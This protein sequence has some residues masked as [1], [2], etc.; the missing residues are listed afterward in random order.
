MKL[1]VLGFFQDIFNFLKA[2]SVLGID[3]GTTSI[4]VVEVSK[5]SGRFKLENYSILETRKY[6]EHPNQAIQTSSLKIDEEEVVELFRIILNELKP[7]SKTV[8]ASMPAFSSFIT[9]IDMPLLS[10]EETAK[11][12]AF[13]AKQYIP[14]PVNEVSIDWLKVEEFESSR[15]GRLQRILLIGVPNEIIK[16]YKNIFKA[17]DLRLITLEVEN[18]SLVRTLGSLDAVTMVVDIG[19]ESTNTII[20]EKGV[21]KHSSQT[22]Y[23]GIHLTQA[24]SK[25]LGI[26]TLRAE[27]LKR[28]RGLLGSGGESE[29]STLILPFLDVII[30][31]VKYARDS[32]ERRYSKKV[33][34]LILVGGGANLLGIEK[35]FGNQMDLVI[36]AP[37]TFANLEYNP[38]L[39]PAVKGLARQ[40]PVA[41]GLAKKYFT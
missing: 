17:A 37:P 28:R 12:V 22:D 26:S 35:Y 21:L 31:E 27:E 20:T 14:L 2:G 23:G 5:K 38:E 15:G 34:K 6:L 33:E 29:L 41:L 3:I 13:Q 1:N 25:S 9:P 18:L 40:L 19:A 16:K 32:Y 24:L 36:T 30:Q 10:T 39:E 11:S 8:L 7:K 4:K